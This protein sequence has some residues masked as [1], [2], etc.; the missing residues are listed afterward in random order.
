M[1]DNETPSLLRNWLSLLGI[2]LAALG[3]VIGVG[4]IVLDILAPFHSPYLGIFTYLVV[5]VI[6]SSGLL[7]ILVGVLRERRRRVRTGTVSL[8]RLPVINLNHPRHM[9]TLVIVV[10]VSFLFFTLSGIGSYRA[11]H[12]S[13]SVTFCGVTCHGVMKPEYTAFQNS[14]HANVTCTKCHIGP[15][16]DWFVKAKING[17]YQVYSV[18]FNKYHRPIEAPVQS[19]RPAQETCHTC[20]WP[21]KFF[22]SIE[23]VRTHHSADETNTPWTVRMLVKVGGGTSTGE[24]EGGSHW[25][26]RAGNKVEYIAAD[27]KRQVIPWVRLTDASGKVTVFR[28]Q[29]AATALTEEQIAA[30]TVRTMDCID[31]HNRPTH[32][33][34]SP[35]RSLDLALADGRID[36]SMPYIYRNALALLDAPYTTEPEA[37]QAIAKGLG[38]QYPGGGPQVE[39]AIATVQDIFAKNIF[40]EMK[41]SWRAY[42]DHI[43]HF[44]APGCARCH[45]GEH[46]SEAGEPITSTCTSCHTILSQGAGPSSQA[47]SPTG[48]AFEHPGDMS[49]LNE[50]IGCYT[51]HGGSNE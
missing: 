27:K 42:P 1:N 43:G 7:L 47:P 45:D 22:G 19:L 15:G 50:M 33:F 30:A 12:F 32:H 6:L 23:R 17:L 38:A 16:A 39:Q 8:P 24:H 36:A 14:P 48:L 25:H 29:D 11:Y 26:V 34:N 28:T 2:P 35:A 9:S 13:E 44:E 49:E 31:C 5:P 46:V 10:V 37:L 40:P 41:V 18:M 4:L 3:F 21:D 51:C 20:H